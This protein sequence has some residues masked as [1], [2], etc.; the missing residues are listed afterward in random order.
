MERIRPL[1]VLTLALIPL[2]VGCSTFNTMNETRHSMMQTVGLEKPTPAAEFACC[3]QNRLQQLPDPTKA[4]ATISGLP[5]QMFLFT[6]DMKPAIPQGELTIAVYDETPRHG[7]PRPAE[8]WHFTKEKLEKMVA[9]DERFGKNIVLF[10]PW[11][12]EWRDV[13]RIRI[14][15]SYQQPEGIKTLYSPESNVVLDFVGSSG[16]KTVNPAMREAISSFA[17][18]N[19]SGV[20]DPN[21]M[22]KQ[23]QMGGAIQSGQMQNPNMNFSPPSQASQFS[24][25]NSSGIPDPNAVIRQLQSG[26]MQNGVVQTGQMQTGQMQSPVQN[27]QYIQTG[28]VQPNQQYGNV[29]PAV[30]QQTP[31]QTQQ[32][33]IIP[34]QQQYSQPNIVPTTVLPASIAPAGQP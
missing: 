2:V 34:V 24:G 5:G 23:L 4:G 16:W 11:P 8:V 19:G 26:Q 33:M 17:N 3:W 27:A 31:Q 21:A 6:G 1:A 30:Y 15:A 20:P 22:I 18:G 7:T 9:V 25:G 14:K 12:D 32:Q 13:S 28:K 10:I 29:I